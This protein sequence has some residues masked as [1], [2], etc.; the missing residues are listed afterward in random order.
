M[1]Q[2]LPLAGER[3]AR[4]GLPQGRVS[5]GAEPRGLAALLLAPSSP[6]FELARAQSRAGEPLANE[7]GSDGAPVREGDRI[8]IRE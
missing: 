5:E 7:N 3:A 8:K 4:P 1:A 2:L 6:A